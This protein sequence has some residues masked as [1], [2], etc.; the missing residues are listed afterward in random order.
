M[1]MTKC[2]TPWCANETKDS[3]CF[4]C[5]DAISEAR[6][7]GTYIC[8]HENDEVCIEYDIYECPEELK[9]QLKIGDFYG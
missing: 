2:K 4:R 6:L 3:Y 5:E 7:E 8:Q 1:K 9:G